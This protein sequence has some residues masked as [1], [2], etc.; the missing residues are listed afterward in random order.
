MI[1]ERERRERGRK[2]EVSRATIKIDLKKEGGDALLWKKKGK[3]GGRVGR[4][5]HAKH[6]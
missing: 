5:I 2:E 1:A 3:G 4:T 6:A